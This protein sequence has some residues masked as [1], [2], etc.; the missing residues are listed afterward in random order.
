MTYDDDNI[1]AQIIDG[2][3]SC[4]LVYEDDRVIAFHDIYPKSKIHVLVLPKKKV[5][6]YD[7][8]IEKSSNDEIAYFFKKINFIAKNILDL[9][10]DGYRVSTNNG[11]NVGQ[12]I[13]HFHVHIQSKF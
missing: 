1:F 11:K 12:I 2:R 5:R 10:N 9:N 4:D 13:F 8:F 6:D 7:S 3:S